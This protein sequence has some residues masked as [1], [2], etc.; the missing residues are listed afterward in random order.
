V[1]KMTLWVCKECGQEVFA[2]GYPSF[3]GW[4]EG[5]VCDFVIEDFLKRG[6]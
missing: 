5:H 3:P 6:D 4:S 2:D 1:I